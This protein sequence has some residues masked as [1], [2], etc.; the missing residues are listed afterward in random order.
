[1]NCSPLNAQRQSETLYF[2]AT[3]AKI[4][5]TVQEYKVADGFAETKSQY[6]TQN[7]LGEATYGHNEPNQSHAA[8]QDAEGN[9]AG[10]FSYIGADGRLLTTNYIADQGGYRVATNALPKTDE[11]AA[12]AAATI[13]AN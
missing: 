7:E 2:A 9:K 10:S 12:P 4:V 8:V 13:I 3:P 6:H 1:M 5:D 11:P